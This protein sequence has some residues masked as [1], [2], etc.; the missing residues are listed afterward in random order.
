MKVFFTV[1][2]S[3]GT[4]KVEAYG[5]TVS[6]DTPSDAF[7]NWEHAYQRLLW[8]KYKSGTLTEQENTIV[9]GWFCGCELSEFWVEQMKYEDRKIK[10][11]ELAERYFPELIELAKKSQFHPDTALGFLMPLIDWDGD[12]EEWDRFRDRAYDGLDANGPTDRTWLLFCESTSPSESKRQ[13]WEKTGVLPPGYK[14]I[15]AESKDYERQ[16]LK[17]LGF[18]SQS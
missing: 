8:E 5:L 7:A 13:K 10:E 16:L 2:L 15:L 1:N 6:G 12:Q 11:R 9:T 14:D 4:V 17:E 3:P 18:R